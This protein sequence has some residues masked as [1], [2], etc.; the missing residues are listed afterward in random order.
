V[1]E[2]ARVVG[3]KRLRPS[4]ASATV[5]VLVGPV[6]IPLAPSAP[7][8]P[9]LAAPRGSLG[10]VVVEAATLRS[11]P[12]GNAYLIHVRASGGVVLCAGPNGTIET[13]LSDAARSPG[14][15]DIVAEFR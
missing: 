11:D 4:H 10:A 13:P 2:I 3:R 7:A 9:W 1:M 6:R 14:G 15:D 12:W 8:E 5:E